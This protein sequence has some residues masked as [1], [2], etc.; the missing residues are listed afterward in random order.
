ARLRGLSYFTQK[1]LVKK[2]PLTQAFEMDL[3]AI[4][5]NI[6]ANTKVI[7]ICSPNNPTGNAMN[8]QDVETILNNF[9]GL[10]VVDEAY[11]NFSRQHSMIS[12]LT[13]YPNLVVLQTFSKAWGLAGIRLGMAFGSLPFI[14]IM[15]KVKPPYNISQ[16]TQDAALA[17]LENVEQVNDWIRQTVAARSQL[18]QEL[19]KLSAVAKVYPSDANFLLVKIQ[20]ASTVYAQLTEMGIIVRDRSRVILCD[21]CLR[22]TIGT[23]D[24]NNTL[25]NALQKITN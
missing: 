25:L 19:S 10:V 22:I 8:R 23:N 20:D 16:L 2:V 5:E 6:D 11:V 3:N 18:A 12:E 14:E 4:A 15:N 24:E 17:A 1:D 7:F 13:E 9:N 21:D